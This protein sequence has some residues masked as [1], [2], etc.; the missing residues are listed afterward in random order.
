MSQHTRRANAEPKWVRWLLTSIA[1]G[2]LALFLG[3]PLIALVISMGAIFALYA[4]TARQSLLL[5]EP[6]LQD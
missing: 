1:L 4:Y 6:S 2:F 5:Q 3:L